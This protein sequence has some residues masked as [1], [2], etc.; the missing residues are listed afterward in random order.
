MGPHADQVRQLDLLKSLERSVSREQV[1]KF[2]EMTCKEEEL[3]D[4]LDAL[5]N[6]LIREFLTVAGYHQH[7]RG[8]WR[9]KRQS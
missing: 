5:V 2:V 9:K 4:R 1:K 6:E 8:E 7:N 3:L